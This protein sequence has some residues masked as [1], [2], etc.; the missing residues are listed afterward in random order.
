MKP[1]KK[2]NEMNSE[3]EIFRGSRE[4][5]TDHILGG[6]AK[7]QAER[8]KSRIN[9]KKFNENFSEDE[10]PNFTFL[11]YIYQLL[12]D[13]YKVSIP[14]NKSDMIALKVAKAGTEDEMDQLNHPLR[15]EDELGIKQDILKQTKPDGSQVK[16]DG[17]G[18]SVKSFEILDIYN[19]L[20]E[21]NDLCQENGCKLLFEVNC[22]TILDQIPPDRIIAAVN[23]R[24]AGKNKAKWGKGISAF[25]NGYLSFDEVMKVQDEIIFLNI[26]IYRR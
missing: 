12:R 10:N 6:F 1:L 2:F 14:R 19:E 16:W 11:P 20:Q 23:A 24:A 13:E 26:Y 5:V 25:S 15:Y 22:S 9:I 18:G 21:I 7:R 8:E 3:S 4:E 17:I